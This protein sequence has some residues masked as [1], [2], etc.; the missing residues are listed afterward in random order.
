MISSGAVRAWR[1]HLLIYSMMTLLFT[2]LG[3]AARR[4]L[5]LSLRRRISTAA[6]RATRRPPIGAVDF[7]DLRRTTPISGDWGFDRGTP[8][9]RHY[10]RAFLETNSSSIRGR[11]LEIDT[12]DYTRSF[13]SGSV[14]R[15]DVLHQ[16][17]YLPGV[18][19][20]GDL[21]DGATIPSDSFDCVIVTQTLQLIYDPAAA[22]RTIHRILKPGGVALCTFPGLSKFTGD[23]Q[24]RWGYYWGF[25]SLSAHRLFSEHFVEGQVELTTYGNPL[26]A[27]AFLFG[28]AAE[29][30]QREELEVSDPDV[31]LLLGVRATK[32][33]SA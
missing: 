18:T 21:T 31:Q 5:P 25:T 29:E 10:I 7:G 28:I 16:S 4:V 20:V 23:N 2:I 8:V 3:G 33:A 24:G 12:D 22:V 14:T 17:D 32:A 9:D 6:Q 11:V 19:M 30:L 15:S 26:S 1:S 13:G 27:A